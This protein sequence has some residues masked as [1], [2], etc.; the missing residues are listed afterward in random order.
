MGEREGD[1]GAAA[2]PGSASGAAASTHN[3]LRPIVAVLAAS[4]IGL[5]ASNCLPLLL[6][7]IVEAFSVRPWEAGL[8]GSVEL[9]GVALSAL[10]LAPWVRHVPRA[11]LALAGAV[12]ATVA[13][14]LSALAESYAMLLS[15]RALAGLGEG[16][17]LAAGL[18]A[19]AA[20]PDPDR[21][22]ARVALL[23]GLGAAALLA[24]L[25][26]AIA[27]WGYA[28]GYAALAVICLAASPLLRW[29]PGAPA[30]TASLRGVTGRS[31]GYRILLGI[32][33]LAVGQG[34]L[35]AFVERIGSSLAIETNSIG[36]ILGGAAL[37]G[38]FGAAA[39]AGLGTRVGRSGPLAVGL[40]AL[41]VG[42]LGLAH[43]TSATA[44]AGFAFTWMLAFLFTLPYVM[45]S[46]AALD[47]GGRWV[48]AATGAST[49][50][51]ALGP[52]LAGILA[53]RFGYPV[54]GWFALGCCA[55][56]IAA[57]VPVV[58]S[59]DRG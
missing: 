42:T 43:A 46:A 29:L 54:L 47:A 9:W 50:G 38:L 39:A 28:G 53:T 40:C 23:G 48:A 31:A 55:C 24:L 2:Q 45:G 15:I 12:V 59:L 7:A 56:A 3:D 16:T 26:L 4:A 10:L 14:L 57:I 41:G 32:G 21:L 58:R 33:I 20:S 19:V 6:G 13:Q 27:P 8:V 37:F 30:A 34:G 25:P 36:R 44:Y 22:Y 35:W 52:V 11:R 17:A 49:I 18:A 5:S 51:T 1:R